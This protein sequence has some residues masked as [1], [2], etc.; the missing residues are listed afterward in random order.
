MA[1]PLIIQHLE[2]ILEVLGDRDEGLRPA[3]ASGHQADVDWATSVSSAKEWVARLLSLSMVQGSDSTEAVFRWSE[4][5]FL[6]Y[7]K[8]AENRV[9][10]DLQTEMPPEGASAVGLMYLAASYYLE[11]RAANLQPKTA[12]LEDRGTEGSVS[13]G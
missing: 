3:L 9:T 13:H 4:S 7:A 11:C 8:H 1:K 5:G 10:D 12:K 2:T 6:V